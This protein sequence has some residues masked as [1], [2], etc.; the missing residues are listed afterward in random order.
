MKS[1][2][3]WLARL[4]RV[5]LPGFT[6]LAL[7]YLILPSIIIVPMSFSNQL[8]LTFPPPGWSTQWYSAMQQDFSWP[9]A[10]INS[11]LIGVPTALLSVA[12]GTFAALA[13]VRGRLRFAAAA[14]G[15]LVAPMLLPHVIIAIGLYP[16]ML[17]LG[18][19][20]GYLGVVIGHTVVAM[21]LVFITV[22]AALRTYSESLELAAM[23]CG[24]GPWRAFRHVTFPMIRMGVLVGGLLAFATSFDELM[25]SLFLTGPGTRTLPRLIWEQMNAYL[26][27]TIAAVATLILAFSLLLLAG[28]AALQSAR[29]AESHP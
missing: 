4:M 19:L 29:P 26:T 5:A 21:P 27:P 20:R 8:Y 17:D 10:A 22:A 3:D 18:L 25:L 13:V 23:T 16:V 12:L 9:Q 1:A 14:S 11:F 24:A 28:V 7:V 15:F 2:V 6:V